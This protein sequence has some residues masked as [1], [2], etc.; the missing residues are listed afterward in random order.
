MFKLL[1]RLLIASAPTDSHLSILESILFKTFLSSNCDEQC[2]TSSY[3][4][5]AA[6]TKTIFN[7]QDIK[8]RKF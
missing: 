2:E 4:K 6:Q 5:F 8:K 7:K 1:F 3:G